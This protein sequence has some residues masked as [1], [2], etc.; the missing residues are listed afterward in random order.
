MKPVLFASSRP[1][2]RA[3]N[4]KA[5]WDAYK[6]E[7]EFVQT[8]A[9][10][11]HPAIRSGRYSLMVID[12]FP[13]ETPGKCIMMWHAI[14]GG[15]KIG[16][17]QPNGYYSM[18]LA[19]LMDCIVTSG[20]GAVK[21]FA[22]CSGLPEDRVLALGMPR[23]DAYIGKKKGDGRTPLA[24]K[25]SY[26][27]APTFRACGETGFP[28]IDWDLLD[29]ELTD[30]EMLIVKPHM[31]CRPLGVGEHEHVFEVPP[32]APTAPY[33]YDC[34]AVIT[35]YSSVMF[36]AYLLGKPVVLFEKV[37]GYTETRGMYL[38]YPGQ[39][40][41]RY[42]TNEEDLLKTLREANALTETEREC[43]RLLADRCDGHAA[44][45]VCTLIDSMR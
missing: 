21:M 24:Q 43:V 31:V 14:Q 37:S 38:D 44:E 39:Y 20:T 11:L 22:E 25:R 29:R 34:D 4:L 10:R 8:N 13:A 41:S 18:R 15:K 36:D 19:P 42:C 35:D 23:T 26:L 40:C 5:V 3:E 30:D 32:D 2:E 45:R 16:L 6:G 17:H 28:A 9:L 7:K 1:L 12:E 27:F 33:L